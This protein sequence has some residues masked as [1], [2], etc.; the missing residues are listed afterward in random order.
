M[1][2]KMKTQKYLTFLLLFLFFES[3]S[4]QTCTGEYRYKKS[5]DT[6][7][8]YSAEECDFILESGGSNS[9]LSSCSSS[10]YRFHNYNSKKCISSCGGEYIFRVSGSNICYSSCAQISNSNIFYE[11]SLNNCYTLQPSSCSYY[12]K[13]LDGVRKCV[14]QS[15]CINNGLKYF[16]GQECRDSCP[17][18]FQIELTES[19]FN[20]IRCYSTLNDA[21][22]DIIYVKFCDL[23]SF[24]CWTTLPDPEI[25][26]I[27]S[28]INSAN[29]QYEVVKECPN[30]YYQIAI[31][32]GST[33]YYFKCVDT[34]QSINYFFTNGVKRCQDN[35]IKFNKHYYDPEN[36]ECLDTC[37]GRPINKFQLRITGT[38]AVFPCK[39]NCNSLNMFYNHDSNVCLDHCGDD[40][41]NNIYYKYNENIC[42]SSC[43][44]IPN[45]NY[46]YGVKDPDYNT[47]KCYDS[48]HI[49]TDSCPYYYLKQDGTKICQTATGCKALNYIYLIGNECR[50]TCNDHYI[51][52]YTI[53]TYT[54]FKCLS[55]LIDCLTASSTPTGSYNTFYNLR[56]RKC[57]PSYPTSY[58]IKDR[59]QIST[60]IIEVVEECEHFYYKL[61][62]TVSTVDV[63]YCTDKCKISTDQN[64]YY[65][66]GKKNCENSCTSFNKYFYSDQN[67][68]LDTCKGLPNLEFA[69]QIDT[70]NP[71][72]QPCQPSCSST[73]FYDS[74][75]NICLSSC[76]SGDPNKK[77]HVYNGKVCY[78]SCADIP[79][80][81]HIYETNFECRTT[82]CQYYNVKPNGVKECIGT[83]DN[84]INKNYKY[85]VGDECRE[86]CDGYFKFEK[87]SP[88]S[89]SYTECFETINDVLKAGNFVKFYNIKSKLCW[90]NFPH[91][92]YINDEKQEIGGTYLKYEV[93]EECDYFFY[94][95]TDP[96]NSNLKYEHCISSCK[97]DLYPPQFFIQ[98]QKNCQL[99]CKD[100][101]RYFYD[102]TNNECLD[103]CKGLPNLEF[104]NKINVIDDPQKCINKC[105]DTSNPINKYYDYDTNLCIINCGGGNPNYLYLNGVSKICYPS[106]KEI[107]NGD[108]KY[109]SVDQPDNTKICYTSVTLPSTCQYYYMKKDGTLKCVS[110]INDC[111][112]MHYNYLL[113]QECKPECN[114]YYK[115]EDDFTLNLI[116][117][118]KTKD[119]CNLDGGALFYNTKYKK[120]W[121]NYPTDYFITSY[122]NTGISFYEVYDEC[123]YFYH[124]GDGTHGISGRYYC[125]NE[126]K[127]AGILNL[128][129]SKGEKKCENSCV[130]FNKY[131]KDTS[132]NECLDTC[133]ERTNMEFAKKV[134][135]G[136]SDPV[137]PCIASCSLV[138]HYNYGEK[139]CLDGPACEIGNYKKF[140]VTLENVCYNSC[141]EIPG[142][143]HIYEIGD[144]CYKES[145]IGTLCPYYYL[146]DDIIRKCE[147]D[148]HNCQIAGYYYLVKQECKA[149]CDDGYKFKDATLNNIIQCYKNIE[150]AIND[151]PSIKYFD[152]IL[153]ECWENIP[154]EYFVKY[155]NNNIYNYFEVVQVCDNFYYEKDTTN[156]INFCIDNCKDI[157]YFF[158]SDN[159]ECKTSCTLFNRYYYNENTNECFDSCITLPD[160]QFSESLGTPTISPQKCLNRCENYYITTAFNGN[161]IYECV[162]TCPFSAAN[163]NIY[164]YIDIK[165]NECLYSCQTDE[166]HLIDNLFCYPYCDIGNGYIY[167]NTD[168]YECLTVCPTYLKNLVQIKNSYGQDLYL[169]KSACKE[170]EFRLGDQCVTKCPIEF[171]YIGHNRICVENCKDDING[172]HYYP[173][174]E[175]TYNPLNDYLIYKCINSCSEG[176]NDNGV[177]YFF[178]T[179]SNPNECLIRCPPNTPYFFLNS[180]PY[181]CLSEC[182]KDFPYYLIP[183]GDNSNHYSCSNIDP[184]TFATTHLLN[185]VCSITSACLSAGKE[186]ISSNNICMD[187]CPENEIKQKNFDANNN[188]DGT[189]T[190]QRNCIYYIYQENI[191]DEPEC[192]RNCPENKNYIGKNN[193]CKQSCDEEDGI[194]FYEL[195]PNA[196]NPVN[197]PVSYKIYQCTNG[198]TGDFHLKEFSNGNQCYKECTTGYPYLSLSEHL[199][200]DICHKSTIMPFSLVYKDQNGIIQ[201]TLCSNSCDND[202]TNINIYFEEN[203]IC[204]ENCNLLGNAKIIDR[205]N[206]CVEKCNFTST[207]R[208]QLNGKCEEKCEEDDPYG[209]VTNPKK[210]YSKGDYLCKEKCGPSENYVIDGNQC[211]STC[212]GF[213]NALNPDEYECIPSCLSINKFYYSL[214]NICLLSCNAND[215]YVEDTHMC[216]SSCNEL[217]NKTYFLYRTT[218]GSDPYPYDA[219]VLECPSNKPYIYNGE[220][221]EICP[222]EKKFFQNEFSHGEIDINRICLTDCPQ[223][224]PF[225]K[226]IINSGKKYYGCQGTCD[227]CFV[228]NEDELITGK[229][230]L[231][232]FPQDNY[233][234]ILETE[235]NYRLTKRCYE[236]CPLEARYHFDISA[237]SSDHNCYETCPEESPYHE[238]GATICKRQSEFI[239]GG[240]IL[241]DI[242]EWVDSTEISKCPS[243]YPLFSKYEDINPLIIC[244]KDCIYEYNNEKYFYLTP[245]NTCVKDCSSTT[246]DLVNT[247]HLINDEINKKCICE[248]LFY[249]DDSTFQIT[250]FAN[251][252]GKTCEAMSSIYYLPLNGTKQCLKSC[253]SER[254]LNPS[255]NICYEKDTP[256]SQIDRNSHLIINSI[257]EIKCE[258]SYKFYFGGRQKYCLGDGAICPEGKKLYVPETMECTD[259]CPSPYEYK[260]RNYCLNLCPSG[261]VVNE[262]AKTCDCG[263]RF[264]IQA[265]D[266]NYECLDGDCPDDYPLYV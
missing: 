223:E 221:V 16:I 185:G 125:T 88:F 8:C 20:I 138:Q 55:T 227:I 244:L 12:Y 112:A 196:I 241:Y 149:S 213:L 59:T 233:N 38:T 183:I 131:Y 81:N 152:P 110:N 89:Q 84:C 145:E 65:V 114:D 180:N 253:N 90:E 72:P 217:K 204:I 222:E 258:C 240:Y 31:P 126:C 175:D 69:N 132:N 85:F 246:L 60:H 92:Y 208:F 102:P 42:F 220:C 174:N 53:E 97:D 212:D 80:G 25:Y 129:F 62:G 266:G 159:K 252:I 219:C 19:S 130:K 33:N 190:C 255:E 30:F 70:N 78:S 18:Y 154:N 263:D 93:V 36:N 172:Q 184:C 9:C 224:Y 50:D 176:I 27:K 48:D 109:E 115:L 96:T 195:E 178:Y 231:D 155:E 136:A 66:D 61:S 216:V 251:S 45:G 215:K 87:I 77:Y 46:N 37:K 197:P 187:K 51:F 1:K 82:L 28:T 194:N 3:S 177:E 68:C 153:K 229:L 238:K 79:G 214:D 147:N 166:H 158:I 124:E 52:E 7:R 24:K 247:K 167:I 151:K 95:Y 134:N 117:C 169:C 101:N 10:S 163:G 191:E 113:G 41:S 179:K 91:G 168:T 6:T 103:T 141:S 107:P 150:E 249:I 76:G 71:T 122:I 236:N 17:N 257:G 157:N 105:D 4:P 248:N 34:C 15:Y 259:Q 201:S 264:W 234:Y 225:Y 119:R 170:N 63:Y 49:P 111:I 140:G 265:T 262:A 135:Y 5:G 123:Q 21:L 14:T 144:T 43:M 100:F 13:K 67:E 161:I 243:E 47:Y 133:V 205:N 57:W 192:I 250:C 32:T 75:T 160:L 73:Q 22:T 40:G 108:Y 210:R 83:I 98:G 239:N 56:L 203:K 260:Y 207:Y 2:S 256:C 211:S 128:F 58:F 54:F 120:C 261:S 121:K 235:I 245:Y 189:Y 206:K 137:E 232:Y 94:I 218:G 230:C 148:I 181:E 193:V 188:L 242:K 143:L 99:S 209:I 35:C 106:C 186:Y 198:C 104:A 171:K 64:Y 226:I 237:G 182:P 39:A 165:T 139:I 146:K 86:N 202:G 74:D 254:I 156:H 11:D 164:N 199:C 228:T 116:K 26:F 23:S 127:I 173:I 162:T 118:Y 142:G 29:L 44:E 200:Y